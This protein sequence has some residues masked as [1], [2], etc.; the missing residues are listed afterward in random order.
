MFTTRMHL[1]LNCGTIYDFVKQSTWWSLTCRHLCAVFWNIISLLSLMMLSYLQWTMVAK[2]QDDEMIQNASRHHFTCNVLYKQCTHHSL[3]LTG[4]NPPH[5]VGPAR[6]IIAL[7]GS[8]GNICMHAWWSKNVIMLHAVILLRT[9]CKRNTEK[10]FVSGINIWL[11]RLIARPPKQ[12]Q[13]D[14][15][16]LSLSTTKFSF[17]LHLRVSPSHHS[18]I[19]TTIHLLQFR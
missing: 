16:S 4:S 14:E 7:F 5:Q 18:A 13:T 8:V 9:I 2:S 6:L 17:L 19:L 15:Q 3:S 10:T 1:T 12:L 11:L